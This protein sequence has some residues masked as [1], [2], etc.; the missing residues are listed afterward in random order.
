VFLIVAPSSARVSIVI[1]VG[2]FVIGALYFVKLWKFNRGSLET[3][4]ENTEMFKH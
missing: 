3:E 2:L 1:V 4:P